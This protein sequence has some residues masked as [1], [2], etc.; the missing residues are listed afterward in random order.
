M[1][2][3]IIGGCKPPY[4]SQD[5]V[6]YKNTDTVNLGVLVYGRDILY[7]SDIGESVGWDG[8]T[9]PYT[10][11][12]DLSGKVTD[13]SK[14]AFSGIQNLTVT[15]LEK[16]SIDELK[17]GRFGNP[18]PGEA[19]PEYRATEELSKLG[20]DQIAIITPGFFLSERG[21]TIIRAP[22]T[23]M[24]F[25]QHNAPTLYT[26]FSISII[27][28]KSGTLAARYI[29]NKG[30]N[31]VAL[32]VDLLPQDLQKVKTDVEEAKK[33][34]EQE[35]RQMLSDFTSE[36]KQAKRLFYSRHYFEKYPDSTKNL[37]K[38]RIYA[39]MDQAF[40]VFRQQLTAQPKPKT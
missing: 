23:G 5:G 26:A 14:K 11:D 9:T 8:G 6:Y 20:L 13:F 7:V 21:N 38:S 22:A 19:I 29:A 24:Y 34:A 25:V 17:L 39:L 4:T 2:P 10:I 40:I 37:I 16:D 30:S 36:E 33:S 18:Y 32:P 1:L 15:Y 31:P 35:V 3:L 27:D 28:V 12:W